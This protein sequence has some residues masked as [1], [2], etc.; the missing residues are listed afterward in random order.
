MMMDGPDTENKV[1]STDIS[2]KVVGIF[3]EINLMIIGSFLEDKSASYRLAC[4]TVFP[5]LM[6]NADGNRIGERKK[7]PWLD[8]PVNE[9]R[10]GMEMFWWF[11]MVTAD[12]KHASIY[13]RLPSLLFL[14]ASHSFIE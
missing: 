7:I 11:V 1:A 4:W 6:E 5:S 13:S 9:H 2:F 8:Q 3:I 12:D 14:S 10:R